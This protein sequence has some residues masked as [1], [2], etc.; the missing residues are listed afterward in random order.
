MEKLH[1]IP[2]TFS[3]SD[4]VLRLHFHVNKYMVVSSAYCHISTWIIIS[5]PV[6]EAA[7][8]SLKCF[9]FFFFLV[10]CFICGWDTTG[11]EEYSVNWIIHGNRDTQSQ[12]IKGMCKQL[13]KNKTLTTV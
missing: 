7:Y 13:N 10:D 12:G 3:S 6:L 9:F 4:I 1:I 11:K 8:C 5:P 2:F